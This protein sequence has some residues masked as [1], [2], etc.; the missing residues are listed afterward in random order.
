MPATNH[1]IAT[2][3]VHYQFWVCTNV[4]QFFDIQKMLM[5]IALPRAIASASPYLP[6][7]S[8]SLLY[9]TAST[10]IAALIIGL[11]VFALGHSATT[12][13]VNKVESVVIFINTRHNAHMTNAT[14]SATTAKKHQI[15][16][17]EVIATHATAIAHLATRRAIQIDAKSLKHITRET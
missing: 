1:Y 2:S 9:H 8:T 6:L 4:D 13:R 17:L 10:H 14:S 16:W 7:T 3:S 12:S 15:S 5:L 11:G